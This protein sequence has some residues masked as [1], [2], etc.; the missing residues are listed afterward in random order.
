MKTRLI[1]LQNRVRELEVAD[2]VFKLADDVRGGQK[3]QP[4]LQIKR[5][6][7]Y[8]GTRELLAPH[9]FSGLSEFED[10]FF[11]RIISAAEQWLTACLLTDQGR[12]AR[13]ESI[14]RLDIEVNGQPC[15]RL[16]DYTSESPLQI[17][18]L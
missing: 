9:D 5:Q 14:E 10:L 8:R 3:R 6:Q 16:G 12:M 13:R 1:Q 18:Q 11:G 15:G 7:R 17:T 2:N 4:D